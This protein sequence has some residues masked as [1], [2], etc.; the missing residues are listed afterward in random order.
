MCQKQQQLPIETHEGLIDSICLWELIAPK[1][2]SLVSVEYMEKLHEM[3]LLGI[4]GLE[5]IFSDLGGW[6]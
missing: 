6:G 3:F 2:S 1:I 5:W 4:L